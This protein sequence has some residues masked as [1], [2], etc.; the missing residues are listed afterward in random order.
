MVSV[1]RITLEHIPVELCYSLGL[2]VGTLGRGI[3]RASR[4][5]HQC[6]RQ[7]RVMLAIKDVVR[8]QYMRARQRRAPQRQANRSLRQCVMLLAQ[9]AE[10]G[11]DLGSMEQTL[12]HIVR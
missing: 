12:T 1:N 8:R 2:I 9:G 10:M 4:I 7:R 3:G 5:G 6:S 11:A